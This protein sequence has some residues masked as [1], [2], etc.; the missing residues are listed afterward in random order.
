[1]KALDASFK[2]LDFILKKMRDSHKV[3]IRKTVSQSASYCEHYG[4]CVENGLA[5]ERLG[6]PRP[7]A[8]RPAGGR[9]SQCRSNGVARTNVMQPGSRRLGELQRC[10]QVGINRAEVS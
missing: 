6:G 3:L 4:C 5:E 8:R 1:M 10:F 9:W 2:T 7:E